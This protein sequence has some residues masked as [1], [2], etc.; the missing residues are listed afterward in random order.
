MKK[1]YR[2]EVD[3]ANCAAKMEAAAV[4]IPGIQAAAVNYLTQKMTLEFAEGADV[5]AATAAVA[6]ACKKIDAD[7]EMN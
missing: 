6:K 5:A 2:I 7:F 1:T 3:C 4:K